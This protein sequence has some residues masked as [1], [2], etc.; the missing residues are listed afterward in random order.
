LVVVVVGA[1]V[2]VVAAVGAVVVVAVGVVVVVVGVVA[3]KTISS[4]LV[5]EG[6]RADLSRT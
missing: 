3:S 6:T 4:T 5:L 1:V 2:V